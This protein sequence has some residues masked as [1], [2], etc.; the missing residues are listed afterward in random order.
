M[1]DLGNKNWPELSQQVADVQ[2]R[3]FLRVICEIGEVLDKQAGMSC[4]ATS[5]RPIAE[6]SSAG[7]PQ[8]KSKTL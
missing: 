8:A 1:S 6:P 2:V 4:P 5:Q 3:A 7:N